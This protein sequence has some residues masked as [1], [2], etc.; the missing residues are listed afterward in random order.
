MLYSIIFNKIDGFIRVW[1]ETR[2]LVLLGSE[3]NDSIYDRFRYIINVK[4][5]IIYIIYHNYATIKVDWF[6]S[7][8]LEK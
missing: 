7:L 6:N 1:N 5:C 4:N 8:P 2:H 3:K